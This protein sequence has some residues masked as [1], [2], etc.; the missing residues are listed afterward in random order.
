MKHQRPAAGVTR[1][2]VHSV[3]ME[4]LRTWISGLLNFANAVLCTAATE[5]ARERT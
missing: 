5:G 1:E 3:H 2:Y 4:Q